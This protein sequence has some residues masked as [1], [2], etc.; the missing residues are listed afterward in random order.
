MNSADD[1]DQSI[2]KLRFTTSPAADERILA[3]ASAALAQAR[4]TSLDASR[5]SVWRIIM[6]SHWTK[7]GAAAA[8]IVAAA[9]LFPIALDETAAPAY[10]IEQTVEATRAVRSIQ[11]KFEPAGGGVGEIWAQF[12]D[13]GELIRLRMDF[14]NTPG[15]GPKVVTW[16]DDKAKVWFK[17]KKG[18]C[19]V[20]EKNILRQIPPGDRQMYFNPKA[21]VEK[22]LEAHAQ[23]KGRIEVNESTSAGEPITLT[24]TKGRQDELRLV[25]QVDPKT[26][27]LRQIEKH[28]RKGDTYVFRSRVKY[29]AYN[30][31]VDPNAFVLDIP[32]DVPCVDQTDPE[33]GLAKGDLTS[34]QVAVKVT[35]EFFEALIA[36]DYVKAG[37]LLGGPSAGWM[38]K[39]FGESTYVR[40]VSVG[41]PARPPKS[42][43][44]KLMV[45]CEVEV[46]RG[47]VKKV[48]KYSVYSRPVYNLPGRWAISGG[49]LYK[50]P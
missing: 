20:H 49:D 21:I 48:E 44:L 42:K 14:P 9:V 2:K 8:V 25:F 10:A 4:K 50:E 38:K 23:G 34:K 32:D 26:K 15:D 28:E 18:A 37:K 22:L 40:V 41:E 43:G 35:R 16:Q 27:L 3:D 19:I 5:S 39:T 47:G 12:D 7:L 46:E 1:I 36:K 6:K 17:R 24:V 11:V 29:V 13:G 33:I 31:S 45:T 30:A